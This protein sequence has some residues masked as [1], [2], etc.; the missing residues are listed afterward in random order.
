MGESSTSANLAALLAHSLHVQGRDREAVAV[1]DVTPAED[2]VSAHVHLSGARARAL[3][4]VGRLDEAE[5]LAR[6][7]VE[8]AEATDFLAMWGDAL[9][10]LASV[11]RRANRVAEARSLLTAALELY[12]QKQHL[13]AID[14]TEDLLRVLV[15]DG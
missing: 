9:S 1:S 10:D 14:R 6:A 12:R 15:Q 8:R 3:A 4:S 2:D 13:V 11:L 7:A 5:L